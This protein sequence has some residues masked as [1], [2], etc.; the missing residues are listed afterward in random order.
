MLSRHWHLSPRSHRP[1]ATPPPGGAAGPQTPS[2][3]TPRPACSPPSLGSA[4][5]RGPVVVP[6][7]VTELFLSPW[8]D[9]AKPA[10]DPAAAKLW[11]LSANDMEDESVVSGPAAR[12]RLSVRLSER[13]AP[14]GASGRRTVRPGLRLGLWLAVLRRKLHIGGVFRAF[15]GIFSP[16]IF[17]FSLP[18][19]R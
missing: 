12:G 9:P 8:S 4:H 18:G 7:V 2:L 5:A 14:G 13:L 6:A 11:T 10:V 3:P 1:R 19:I 15:S 16:Q 17:L